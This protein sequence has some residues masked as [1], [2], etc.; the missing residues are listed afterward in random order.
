MNL[1]TI[2]RSI[3]GNEIT[4]VTK[5][6]LSRIHGVR[7]V[8]HKRA[9]LL[10]VFGEHKLHIITKKGTLIIPVKTFTGMKAVAVKSAINK[11]IKAL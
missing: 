7:S 2:A 6:H 5:L 8:N 10:T 3:G 4:T 9:T 1:V 11:A